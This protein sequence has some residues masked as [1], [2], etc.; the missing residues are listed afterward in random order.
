MV[1]AVLPPP[2]PPPGINKNS[3][4][5]E[6]AES[7]WDATFD[8]NTKGVF[9][10]CQVRPTNSVRA[11]PDEVPGSYRSLPSQLC[12]PSGCDGTYCVWLCTLLAMP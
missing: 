6:T 2:P 7:D 5:E 9:L 12:S 1:P 4:A 10:C 11:D 3:A 8:I